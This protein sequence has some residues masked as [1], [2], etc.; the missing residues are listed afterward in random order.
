M[1]NIRQELQSDESEEEEESSES[2]YT[3]HENNSDEESE[4]KI[5]DEL[6]SQK[7]ENNQIKEEIKESSKNNENISSKTKAFSSKKILNQNSLQNTLKSNHEANK[8]KEE[9]FYH[10]NFNKISLYIFNYSTGYPEIQK[11]QSYK[12]SHVTYLIN[13]EKEKLK[14]SNSK[15]LSNAKFIKGKKKGNIIKKEEN[16]F[17]SFNIT[18]VKLKELYRAL[19]THK[20]ESSVIKMLFSSIAIFILIIGMG[21]LNI[22]IYSYIKSNIN[23][24]FILIQKSGYLYQNL[25]FEFTIVKEMLFTNNPYYNI[26]LKSNKTLYFESLKEIIYNYYNDNAYIISNLTN[27]FNILDKKD[28]DIL[29]KRSIELLIIDPV[30]SFQSGYVNKRYSVLVYSAYREMNSALYHIS[31]MKMEDIYQYDD[32]VYYFMRN[33]LSSLIMSCEDQ[34]LILTDKFTEKIKSGQNLII[35]CCAIAF[36]ICA[37]CLLIFSHFYK[38]VSK[39]KQ[40]YLS[41]FQQL[42]I[43][44]IILYLQKCEKFIN[45]LLKTKQNKD[46]KNE[47]ISS[48]SSSTMYSYKEND[49]L[50]FLNNQKKKDDKI[51]Q[52]KDEN[53]I[54]KDKIKNN[55]IF[56]YILFFIIFICQLAI[57]FFYYQKINLYKNICTYE[58]YISMFAS[59][60]IYIFVALREYIFDRNSILYNQTVTDYLNK[61]LANYYVIFSNKSK[62]KDIYRVYFPDS[63]QVFLNYLYSSKICEF[64]DIYSAQYPENFKINCNNF[65]YGSSK[66]GFFSLLLTFVEEVRLMKDKINYYYIFNLIAY[67]IFFTL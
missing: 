45:K 18:S 1:T 67:F 35:I 7:K 16:E 29:T 48:N 64:I 6:M 21:F 20:N 37:G 30:R 11:G 57:Y 53:I 32:D 66:F 63:Y 34:M 23:T 59:H 9:D 27:N 43:N 52:S 28:E 40:N 39:K 56:R 41:I 42:D 47:R 54:K 49:N 8:K 22:L 24:F 55:N 61:N 10:V 19:S 26:T 31:Q 58:Y 5:S 38:N 17:N 25:L 44:L 62:T 51:I 14:H 4:K 12:I 15:F 2:Y 33:G 65:F 3:S 60:F 50:A 46:S 36:I 13:T